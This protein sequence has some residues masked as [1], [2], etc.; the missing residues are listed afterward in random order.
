MLATLIILIGVAGEYEF[1]SRAADVSAALQRLSDKAVANTQRDAKQAE[2]RAAEAELALA[3]FKAPRV[4]KPE[5]QNSIAEKLKEF[6]GQEYAGLIGPG[7]A[8][9]G[10]LW[11][12]ISVA[13]NLA[14]WKPW[15]CMGRLVDSQNGPPATIWPA[16]F[17]RLADVNVAPQDHRV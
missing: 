6:A 11:R 13:L 10:H 17:G 8:D 14:G 5:Q 3:Q 4:I 15:C 16:A 9:A 2:Q 12:D 7:V 1:G